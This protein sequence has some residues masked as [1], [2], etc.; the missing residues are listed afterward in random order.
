M[1]ILATNLRSV[2]KMERKNENPECA[3]IL[4]LAATKI[5]ELYVALRAARKHVWSAAE[6][7][8][9][10]DGFGPRRERPSD[11]DLDIV[12]RALSE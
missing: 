2:A 7:E 8:H 11:L 10:M 6:S 3:D 12:D 1:T 4:D 9:M 5:D